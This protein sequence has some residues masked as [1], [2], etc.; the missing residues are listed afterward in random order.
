MLRPHGVQVLIKEGFELV[1]SLGGT[2]FHGRFLFL[3]A[4]L[5]AGDPVWLRIERAEDRATTSKAVDI[6][7]RVASV[8]VTEAPNGAGS[9]WRP[10]PG[11]RFTITIDKVASATSPVE[12]T[13]ARWTLCEA[14][15]SADVAP[16]PTE[17]AA[18]SSS[19]AQTVLDTV[20]ERSATGTG[21]GSTSVF[22]SL[23]RSAVR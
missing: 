1:V 12:A 4:S 3:P 18:V 23:H 2:R 22:T 13:R 8:V 14:D 9:V 21:L 5:R 19:W 10:L 16:D 7:G 6:T 20:R 17:P 15:G 11:G